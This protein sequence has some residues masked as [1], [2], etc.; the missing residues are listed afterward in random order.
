MIRYF[1][2][3][4]P[5]VFINFCTVFTNYVLDRYHYVLDNS[6]LPFYSVL[7]NFFVQF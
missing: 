7:R 5:R 6:H 1:S 2:I 3:T 4:F